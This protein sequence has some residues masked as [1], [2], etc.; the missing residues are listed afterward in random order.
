ME[1]RGRWF[2]QLLSSWLSAYEIYETRLDWTREL[3]CANGMHLPSLATVT[4]AG[5]SLLPPP[6][7]GLVCSSQHVSATGY[8]KSDGKPREFVVK[9]S[10]VDD[11]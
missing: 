11:R 3:Q 4:A 5:S 9:G 2:L 8:A 7:M 1:F 10:L 6:T